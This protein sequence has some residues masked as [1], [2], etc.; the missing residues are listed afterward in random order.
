MEYILCISRSYIYSHHEEDFR[1]VYFL[2]NAVSKSWRSLLPF[3]YWETVIVGQLSPDTFIYSFLFM[4]YLYG[5]AI[6]HWMIR[7]EFEE[8]ENMGHGLYL[9]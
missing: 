2:L 5:V 9:K 8:Q 6:I 1:V 4:M 7:Y 3:A